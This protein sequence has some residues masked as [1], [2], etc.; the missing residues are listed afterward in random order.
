MSK[1]RPGLPAEVREGRVLLTAQWEPLYCVAQ[2]IWF[3]PGVPTYSLLT[4]QVRLW[5]GVQALKAA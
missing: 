1:K 5:L 4:P 3:H 2:D